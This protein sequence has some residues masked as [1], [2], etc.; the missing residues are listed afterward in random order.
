MNNRTGRDFEEAQIDG[1]NNLV[2]F[3][4]R[5][6]NTAPELVWL[7]PDS[8]S[9]HPVT[10]VTWKPNPWAL[11]ILSSSRTD[12]TVQESARLKRVEEASEMGLSERGLS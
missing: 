10:F 2:L 8:G 7:N 11:S 1:S 4:F 9:L 12:S 3:S 6:A 5:F